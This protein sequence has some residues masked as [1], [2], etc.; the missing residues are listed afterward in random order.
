[1]ESEYM[2][3]EHFSIS[4]DEYVRVCILVY[5]LPIIAHSKIYHY[6]VNF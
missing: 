4:V 3:R 2:K 1:M 6:F 5:K